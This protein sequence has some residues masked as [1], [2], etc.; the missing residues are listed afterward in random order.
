MDEMN[1]TVFA[2]EAPDKHSVKGTIW[3]AAGTARGIIQIF[4]GLGEHHGRYERFA[5]LAVSRGYVVVAHD[6]RG[7]GANTDEL[8][9][10]AESDGWQLLCDDGLLVNEMIRERFDNLPIVLLGHSMGSFIAQYFAM[11]Q[12]QH[13]AAL[14][15]SGSTWPSRAKLIP[16]LMIAYAESW[17][18]GTHGKSALLDK[19][20]FGN[21]NRPFR[22]AR[23]ELDWLSRDTAEVDAYIADPL[24]GGP[25]SCGLWLDLIRAFIRIGSD[26]EISRI[27]SDLPMLLSGGSDDPVGGDKGITKLALHYAQTMHGRLTVKLYD[28]G[29]HEMI[30]EINREAFSNDILDWIDKQL[31]P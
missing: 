7:H 15:L 24:C 13:L 4:H 28:G 1:S 14:V 23:T 8:G 18:I 27:R 17:R 19:L 26:N 30:N 11:F 21:F 29:R 5:K 16:G 2:L 31:P 20:G 6:H 10:F 3:Q 25:Y 22:P 12:H 9:F